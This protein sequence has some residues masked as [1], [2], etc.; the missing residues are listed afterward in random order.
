MRAHPR[1][2]V[3]LMGLHVWQELRVRRGRTDW[4]LL[5]PAIVVAL[6]FFRRHPGTPIMALILAAM[7]MSI[8]LTW[9][10]VGKFIVPVHP[11]TVAIVAAM[12]V[13]IVRSVVSAAR[14]LRA[15]SSAEK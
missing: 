3:N 8:A 1:D 15:D 5:V 6:V 12:V 9:G 11:I 10:S 7:L 14:R 4:T 2:V 13:A